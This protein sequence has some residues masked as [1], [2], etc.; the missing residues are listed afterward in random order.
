[1]LILSDLV[2]ALISLIIIIIAL[3]IKIIPNWIGFVLGFIPLFLF[4][5]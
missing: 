2:N 5:K 4:F 3:R 1:M